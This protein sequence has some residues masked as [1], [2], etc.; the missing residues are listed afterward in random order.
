MLFNRKKVVKSPCEF[1]IDIRREREWDEFLLADKLERMDAN[2]YDL[3]DKT[4]CDFH[5]DRYRFACEY[6]EGKNVV[7]CAS[8]T[9]YGAHLLGMLGRS[10]SVSGVE[11]ST[12]AVEYACVTYAS[13]NVSFQQGTI[14]NLPFEDNSV[15]IFTSFETIEHVENENGQLGEI[16]RVLKPGGVYIMSTPNDWESDAL[17]PHHVRQYDFYSLQRALGGRF[18]IMKV[19]NQNSGTPGREVNRK[20]PRSIYLSSDSNHHLAECFIVVARK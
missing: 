10:G 15:D 9:G 7:D 16:N 8:G 2:R 1:S 13:D 14:L 18:E 19:Y 4:R 3:F 6:T 11:Y 5:L 20:Q 12:E 17:H